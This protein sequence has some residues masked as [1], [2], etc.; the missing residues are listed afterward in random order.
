MS[1]HSNQL[2]DEY[3]TNIVSNRRVNDSIWDFLHYDSPK[4]QFWIS[5]MMRKIESELGEKLTHDDRAK[6]EIIEH[7]P[8]HN[9]QY[10]LWFGTLTLFPDMMQFL[11]ASEDLER[12]N[13]GIL[14]QFLD[15]TIFDLT[16]EWK[17]GRFRDVHSW[18]RHLRTVYACTVPCL[19]YLPPLTRHALQ[20]T[21]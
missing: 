3:K 15:Q 19:G 11:V 10:A 2:E 12:A 17:E 14:A 7:M 20:L 6:M 16:Q 21:Q 5:G 13:V 8:A 4:R 18:V 1:L 9:S